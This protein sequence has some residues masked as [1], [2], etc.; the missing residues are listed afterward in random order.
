[1]ERTGPWTDVPAVITQVRV[2][3]LDRLCGDAG[4]RQRVEEAWETYASCEWV[5]KLSAECG[6]LS[7]EQALQL[8]TRSVAAQ[9]AVAAREAKAGAAAEAA[10]ALPE[11]APQGAE[12]LQCCIC[13]GEGCTGQCGGEWAQLPCGHRMHRCCLSTWFRRT[14]QCPLCRSRVP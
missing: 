12:P 7:A 9:L 3:M 4:L 8:I 6:A 1:M 11:P 10:G 5:S 2:R 13:L 14:K